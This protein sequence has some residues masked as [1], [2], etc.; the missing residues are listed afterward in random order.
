VVLLALAAV[1]IAGAS[2]VLGA[3]PQ[4]STLATIAIAA[5]A[6]GVFLIVPGMIKLALGILERRDTALTRWKRRSA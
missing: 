6:I 5:R 2:F 3:L 4:F 1:L